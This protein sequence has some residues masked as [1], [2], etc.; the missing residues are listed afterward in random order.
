MILAI[1]FT[2]I[3]W[4]VEA[5]PLAHTHAILRQHLMSTCVN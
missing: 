5:I 3:M 1:V 2:E 4:Q